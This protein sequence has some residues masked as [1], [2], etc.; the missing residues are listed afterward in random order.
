M[1]GFMIRCVFMAIIS[2]HCFVDKQYPSQPA[3][4]SFLYHLHLKYMTKG[5]RSSYSWSAYIN[6]GKRLLVMK[7]DEHIVISLI[8]ST[9]EVIST[10]NIVYIISNHRLEYI[11]RN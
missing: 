4:Q 7:N 9:N 8:K 2:A 5:L 10:N 1:T 6:R 3:L 11:F